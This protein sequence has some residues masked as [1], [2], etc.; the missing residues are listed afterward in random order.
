MVVYNSVK[1][2]IYTHR[3]E[4]AIMRLVGASNLFVY[5]PFILSGIIFAFVGVLVILGIFYLFL[6]L[7]QPYIEAFFINYQVNIISYYNQHILYIFGLQLLGAILVNVI[8]SLIAVR[9]YAKV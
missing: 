4:I 3:K 7:L 2:G 1:V 9:K 8:A 5:M 6:G